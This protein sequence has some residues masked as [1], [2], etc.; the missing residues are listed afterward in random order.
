[1]NIIHIISP[2]YEILEKAVIVKF[3]S[4]VDKAIEC[5][6]QN[7]YRRQHED[8]NKLRNNIYSV[9]YTIPISWAPSTESNVNC[10]GGDKAQNGTEWLEPQCELITHST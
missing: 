10:S 2:E 7:I 6:I 8:K 5:F 3:G 4:Y 1:M 9:V